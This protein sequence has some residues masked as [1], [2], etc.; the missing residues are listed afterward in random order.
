MKIAE[1]FDV[2]GL[3]T[4]VTGAASGIGYAY[5]EAMADN[6]AHVA[7]LDID[8]AGL[9]QAVSKL[10]AKGGDVRG[11]M[12]D[13]TDRPALR[14]AV[15]EAARAFGR[16]DVLFANVGID[17]APGFL[18][19]AGE[20]TIEGAFENVSDERWDKVIATN[21]TSVFTSIRAAVPHMKKNRQG[22]RIIVTTSVAAMRSEAIV[23]MPYM[24]AK[25]GVAH[26][27]RQAAIELAKFNILVNAIAPGPFITNIA[28]G[29]MRNPEVAKAFG[30]SVP[31]HRVASTDEI[32]GAALFLASSASTFV[33]GA[34]IIVDGGVMLGRAD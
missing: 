26:L 30:Q 20:R 27:V 18:S 10:K 32:Q 4:I 28:G 11:A 19:M 15:D 22:G 34:Q 14:A 12:V 24:P 33:T 16:L 13:V 25:A 7:M 8:R 3:A 1:L 31:L 29:H 17:S 23:G 9:D 6:G 21:F 5:A 2:H